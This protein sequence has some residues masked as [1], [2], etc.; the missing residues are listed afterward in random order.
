[1]WVGV[2]LS[3]SLSLSL[4]FS[5]CVCE[6]ERMRARDNRIH[7]YLYIGR[8]RNRK[9]SYACVWRFLAG[10]AKQNNRKRGETKRKKRTNEEKGKAHEFSFLYVWFITEPEH[11]EREKRG[12]R[13]R[14]T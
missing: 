5:L 4:S 13:R 9:V 1:M 2:C 8:E 7:T 11:L 10:T 6:R 3:L 14:N 12:K